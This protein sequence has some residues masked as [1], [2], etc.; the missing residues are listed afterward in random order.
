MGARAMAP[1]GRQ[2]TKLTIGLHVWC[3]LIALTACVKE[4]YQHSLLLVSAPSGSFTLDPT[5]PAVWPW[6]PLALGLLSS[7][8]RSGP[9][10]QFLKNASD[11]LHVLCVVN[12]RW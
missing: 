11:E 2:N 3:I 6:T 5:P 7:I 12:I 9:V 8:L 10:T 1:S 4:N